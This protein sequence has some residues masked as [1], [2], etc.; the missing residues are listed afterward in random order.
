MPYFT[1]LV[2]LNGKN[3]SFVLFILI[4]IKSSLLYIIISRLFGF[5]VIINLGLS[6]SFDM[7]TFIIT[8]YASKFSK[9]RL[10]LNRSLH[11]IYQRTVI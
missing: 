8:G 9:I 6:P 11:I 10:R 4:Q 3:N 7:S 1:A 2:I 5:Y